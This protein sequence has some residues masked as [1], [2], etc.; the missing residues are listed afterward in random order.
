MKKVYIELIE[1][2]KSV[3]MVQVL[4]G[5]ERKEKLI[6][7]G[8]F[9]SSITASLEGKNFGEVNSPIFRELKGVKL[10]Q[11][12]QVGTNSHTYV[13]FQAKHN[14]PLE[15]FNR[16]YESVGVPNLLYGV[17]VINNRLSKLYVVATKDT[18]IV[19]KTKLYKYPFTNVSGN[20][21]S[22][23]LGRNTFG[24]GIEDN[25]LEK[26]YNI[27]N[28]FMS[29]PNNLDY[30]RIQNNTKCYECEQLFK[31]LNNNTF[32]DYLL[33][34]NGIINYADWFNQL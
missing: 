16:F 1:D 12:K 26:L 4:A 14:T 21:G 22:A 9:V 33:V 2:S 29:M 25:D 15:L 30:Y 34:E 13:L 23:C 3:N 6:R 28:Q 24:P 17:K 11:S 20:S 7:I 27:P 18:D 5:G 19:S 10:I 31:V 32:D 8:D